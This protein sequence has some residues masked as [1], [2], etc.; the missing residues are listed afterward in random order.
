MYTKMLPKPTIYRDNKV[1][2]RQNYNVN[3]VF[4]SFLWICFRDDTKFEKAYLSHFHKGRLV[5][6]SWKGRLKIMPAFYG[7]DTKV[8]LIKTS[9]WTI[10]II[11][12]QQFS[13][14]LANKSIQ[15]PLFFPD[16]KR[17]IFVYFIFIQLCKKKSWDIFESFLE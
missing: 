11:D 5:F 1:N 14:L 4:I 2:L 10:Q 8:S 12:V 7:R 13:L 17:T 3:N 16:H 9:S 6:G 15:S